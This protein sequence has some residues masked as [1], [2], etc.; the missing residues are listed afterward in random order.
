VKK[1]MQQ[2]NVPSFPRTKSCIPRGRRWGQRNFASLIK[3]GLKD[4][5]H[6]NKACKVHTYSYYNPNQN[7]PF[8]LGTLPLIHHGPHLLL[9]LMLLNILLNL[10]TNLFSHIHPNLLNGATHHKGGGLNSTNLLLYYLHL[11]P[12]PQLT[13]PTPP[14]QP[15]MPAQPNLNPNNKQAQQVYSGETSYPAYVVE[16]Q[17]INLRSGRV[18]P[19]NHPPSPPE[20]LEE[21][22]EESTPQ[23]NPPPFPERLIHPNQHTPEE[24]EL[25]G[26]HKKWK[27]PT[28]A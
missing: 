27:I 4:L 11:Q 6:I 25:M 19:D 13:H 7:A 10:S 3:G 9:G 23:V 18:L 20:E 24:V 8:H 28:N 26:G 2:I 14:K 5:G 15:Q 1:I 21:E 12:Q 22:K 16:I 17:E